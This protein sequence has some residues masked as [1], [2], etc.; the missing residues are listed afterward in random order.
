MPEADRVAMSR[1]YGFRNPDGR[2][3]SL[4][5]SVVSANGSSNNDA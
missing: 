3:F 5:N 2:E 4:A 1:K